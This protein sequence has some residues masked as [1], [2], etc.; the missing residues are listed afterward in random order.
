MRV[1]CSLGPKRVFAF[2]G[3]SHYHNIMTMI[4]Y[5][6]W[7]Y[8]DRNKIKLVVVASHNMCVCVCVFYD[9]ILRRSF[10]IFYGC[11]R[12]PPKS[13]LSFTT[14]SIYTILY[15]LFHFPSKWKFQFSRLHST[16]VII[17]IEII[18]YYCML[19]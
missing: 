18:F 3:H 14:K 15:I 19:F 11:C 7:S 2:L 13:T 6:I 17:R 9:M 12:F 4:L 1:S 8:N 10:Y 5:C 16:L